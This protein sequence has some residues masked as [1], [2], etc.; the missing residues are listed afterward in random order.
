MIIRPYKEPVVNRETK[1]D[2]YETFIF[3]NF[4]KSRDQ[5]TILNANQYQEK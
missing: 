3:E 4:V 2:F 1:A 5:T